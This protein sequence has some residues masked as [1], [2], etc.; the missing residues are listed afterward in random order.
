M[1]RTCSTR[2]GDEKFISHYWLENLKGR[3]RN[4]VCLGKDTTHLFI[5]CVTMLPA[6]HAVYYVK[7]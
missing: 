6:A 4:G 7:W 2:E 5:A 1:S 3:R